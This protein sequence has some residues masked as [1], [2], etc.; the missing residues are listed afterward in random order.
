MGYRTF[1]YLEITPEPSETLL[2][3]TIDDWMPVDRLMGEGYE[4]SWDDY[5]EEMNTLSQKYPRYLFILDGSG[6]SK[7]DVWR[8]FYQNGKTYVW[9][10][11]ET[12]APP[13][14]DKRMFD[15]P[16]PEQLVFDD[17]LAQ[18][19]KMKILV[20]FYNGNTGALVGTLKPENNNILEGFVVVMLKV[21]YAVEITVDSK[22]V[23]YMYKLFEVDEDGF[24]SLRKEN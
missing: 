18:K 13:D 15:D 11:P 23:S 20:S 9:V 10:Q 24:C 1:Y 19:E 21:G 17:P 8:E 7:E 6:D 5:A 2:K 16:V 3:E 12:I 22:P 14:F 4:S